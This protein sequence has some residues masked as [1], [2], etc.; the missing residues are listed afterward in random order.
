MVSPATT[1][2]TRE[3]PSKVGLFNRRSLLSLVGAASMNKFV[4]AKKPF[5][6]ELFCRHH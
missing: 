6:S 1:P 5:L 3:G 4:G 2:T